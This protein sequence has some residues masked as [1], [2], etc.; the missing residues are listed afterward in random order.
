MLAAALGVPFWGNPDSSGEVTRRLGELTVGSPVFRAICGDPEGGT[1]ISAHLPVLYGLAFLPSVRR[2]LEIGVGS[3]YS[4][5]AMYAGLEHSGGGFLCS[6]DI[7]DCSRALPCRDDS[8]VEWRFVQG[9]SSL[10]EKRIERELGDTPVDLVFL[11][12]FHSFKQVVLDV[13]AWVTRERLRSGG[14]V[15]F[16][17]SETMVGVH[18][19]VAILEKRMGWPVLRLVDSNGLA[20]GQK[21]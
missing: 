20:V 12:G 3:G 21:P 8:G 7:L 15:V 14:L 18:T 6:V 11:D 19:A 5:R 2:I 9:H 13:S 16:H 17:D 1:D 10:D 4:T